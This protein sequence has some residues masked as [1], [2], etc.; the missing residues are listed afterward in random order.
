VLFTELQASPKQKDALVQ[1]E[2]SSARSS[3]IASV[4]FAQF[5]GLAQLRAVG[6]S[7]CNTPARF[8]AASVDVRPL[9]HPRPDGAVPKRLAGHNR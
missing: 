6:G 8:L 3:F 7:Q 5:P 2:V 1:L 4:Y 9:D